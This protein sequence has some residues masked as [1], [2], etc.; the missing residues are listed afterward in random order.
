MSL[1]FLNCLYLLVQEESIF[2]K[3]QQPGKLKVKKKNEI[4]NT[5]LLNKKVKILADG[6]NVSL[7]LKLDAFIRCSK[8]CMFVPGFHN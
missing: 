7:P 1:G 3:R 4:E 5:G 6:M 2:S 8:V